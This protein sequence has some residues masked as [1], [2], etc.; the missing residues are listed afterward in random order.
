MVAESL[1]PKPFDVW[2]AIR[3]PGAFCGHWTSHL[4]RRCVPAEKL[5][6]RRLGLG[7]PTPPRML[8]TELR[9]LGCVLEPIASQPRRADAQPP[10]AAIA[11]AS[12]SL[13]AR[14]AQARL[15]PIPTSQ[16]CSGGG[17][18]HLWMPEQRCR[19]ARERAARKTDTR[20]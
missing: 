7:G 15:H 3:E 12:R 10:P 1:M 8:R 14:R 13:P 6:V 11:P 16:T 18:L 2:F 17:C 9:I 19:C 5:Q 4:V 20:E